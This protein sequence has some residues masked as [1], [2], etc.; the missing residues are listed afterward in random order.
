[1]AEL[2]NVYDTLS[3]ILTLYEDGELSDKEFYSMICDLHCD[4]AGLLN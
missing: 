4:L 2:T 3:S 1:M